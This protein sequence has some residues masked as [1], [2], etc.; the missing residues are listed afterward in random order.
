MDT[1][2]LMLKKRREEAGRLRWMY[3]TEFP[4]AAQQRRLYLRIAVLADTQTRYRYLEAPASGSAGLFAP[5]MQS[6]RGVSR[7]HHWLPC[8]S[9]TTSCRDWALPCFGA[10][11]VVGSLAGS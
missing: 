10:R 9:S 6:R 2:E 4:L 7:C 11:G 5:Y 8:G 1:G 3:G